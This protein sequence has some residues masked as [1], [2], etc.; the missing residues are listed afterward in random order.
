VT[1][2]SVDLDGSALSQPA[3]EPLH[4]RLR[5]AR[6]R[7]GV[8]LEALAWDSRI[9]LRYFQAIESGQLQ[10]LPAGLYRR[11]FLRTYLGAIGIVEAQEVESVV[12]QL[13]PAEPDVPA[14]PPPPPGR[15]AR[16]RPVAMRARPM[17]AAGM[18]VVVC[19]LVGSLIGR[20]FLANDTATP[21][22]AAEDPQP[23][24]PAPERQAPRPRRQP[25][26]PPDA[27]EGQAPGQRLDTEAG[28]APVAGEP[29]AA[30]SPMATPSAAEAQEAGPPRARLRA[31][32]RVWLRIRPATGPERELTLSRGETI[33]FDLDGP[34]ELLVGN[35]G[36]VELS[37]DG[38]SLPALGASGDVRTIVL[39]PAEL[40]SL[41]GQ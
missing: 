6:L 32:E 33:D 35:A 1:L 28:E 37:V 19:V 34:A 30:P 16:G 36:G 40:S 17:V 25:Q 13:V 38:R 18:L 12:A 14:L 26:V 27:S 31:T 8:D 20:V 7:A 5:Q 11:N 41:F 15:R 2:K 39:D 21:L 22:A 23:A 3:D 24:G 4:E 29:A 9:Q 10:L